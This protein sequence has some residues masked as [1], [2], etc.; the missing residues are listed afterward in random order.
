MLQRLLDGDNLKEDVIKKG[1]ML[2]EVA[3]S[4]SL[5]N[6]VVKRS[7]HGNPIVTTPYP[8]HTIQGKAVRFDVYNVEKYST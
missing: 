1:R 7:P 5:L 3:A 6:I 2:W 4:T 8:S